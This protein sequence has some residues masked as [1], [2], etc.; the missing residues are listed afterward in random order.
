MQ[1]GC[2][3]LF[4]HPWPVRLYHILS[5]YYINETNYGGKIEYKV[6]FYFVY[7]VFLNIYNLR[8]IQEGNVMYL[9]M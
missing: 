6:C 3:L 1:C 2:A 4:C 5:S 8:R 7:I 9:Y